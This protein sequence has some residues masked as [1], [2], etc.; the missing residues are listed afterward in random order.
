VH[1]NDVSS[2]RQA[3][4]SNNDC[5][6]RIRDVDAGMRHVHQLDMEW[7]VNF[8]GARRGALLIRVHLLVCF[9][10]PRTQHSAGLDTEWPVNFTGARRVACRS[11]AN[12]SM[13]AMSHGMVR[14]TRPSSSPVPAA[15]N[16][17]LRVVEHDVGDRDW[18]DVSSGQW[19]IA[20]SIH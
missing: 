4:I 11:A 8:T 1:N 18:F 19:T 2:G 12:H 15:A 16:T 20:C 6:V 5:C 7:P 17:A 9:R 14:R 13:V 3:V 10:L